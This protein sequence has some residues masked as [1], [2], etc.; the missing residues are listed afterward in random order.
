MKILN[1]I[2]SIKYNQKILDEEKLLY[3]AIAEE[4][5]Y[6]GK[7]SYEIRNLVDDIEICI[8]EKNDKLILKIK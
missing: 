4:I 2:E 6:L 3:K 7:K 5:E 1:F 8:V